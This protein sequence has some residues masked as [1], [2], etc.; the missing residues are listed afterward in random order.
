[1]PYPVTFECDYVEKRSRLT[2]FFRLI[3][4]IPHL[5]VVSLYGI[6]AW[7]VIVVAWFALL[8]TGRWPHGVYDFVG[9]FWR[10]AT[11]VYGYCYLLTDDYPAFGPDVDAYPVRLNIAPPPGG[12]QPPEG[13]SPDHPDDPGLHH[14]LHA[15]DI[16]AQVGAFLR[17]SRS[18]SSGASRRGLAG[19]DRARAV[20]PAA[21][22]TRTCR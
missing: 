14:R 5:I 20:L 8:F 10:Y 17:G 3:L 18:S 19:H 9:G 22:V 2:T 13:L 11:A 6:A 12:V 16:V 4:A 1:M 15:E 21:R 7:V